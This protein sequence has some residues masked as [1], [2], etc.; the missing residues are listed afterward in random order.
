M[1]KDKGG[2]RNQFH[3]VIDI[4]PTILDVT[5]ISAPEIVDGIAQKP[6]EGVS[7]ATLLILKMPMHLH[8]IK[9]NIS[10]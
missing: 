3:H 7:L 8:P 1:I 5:G 9:R 10:R 2:I 4:V 6:I